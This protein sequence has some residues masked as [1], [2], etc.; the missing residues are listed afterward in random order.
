MGCWGL[1][2][3]QGA[4]HPE[5]LKIM[6]SVSNSLEIFTYWV[7]N[8]SLT[9]CQPYGHLRTSFFQIWKMMLNVVKCT[10][11][12]GKKAISW[13]KEMSASDVVG[14]KRL[15]QSKTGVFFWYQVTYS[16]SQLSL[17]HDLY[18]TVKSWISHYNYTVLIFFK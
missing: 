7:S 18:Q 15:H 2:K 11:K 14:P 10:T 1:N 17:L 12:K 8:W 9:F 5:N 3:V 6:I 13:I 4:K 16:V